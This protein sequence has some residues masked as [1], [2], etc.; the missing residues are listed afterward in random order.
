M[1]CTNISYQARDERHLAARPGGRHAAPEHPG[2]TIVIVITIL[3]S[4]MAIMLW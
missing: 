1:I 2:A 4:I 3:I